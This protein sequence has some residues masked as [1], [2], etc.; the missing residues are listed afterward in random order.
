MKSGRD[1][2]KKTK[3]KTKA[4]QGHKSKIKLVVLEDKKMCQSSAR[5]EMELGALRICCEGV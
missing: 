2:K 5:Q 3:K 4:L 1:S